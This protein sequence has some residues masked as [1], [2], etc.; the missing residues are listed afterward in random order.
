MKTLLLLAL[1]VSGN[2]FA[3]S[4]IEK[5]E[6]YPPMFEASC[7]NQ[8]YDRVGNMGL[9]LTSISAYVVDDRIAITSTNQ[10]WLCSDL[11]KDGT[12]TKMRWVNVDPFKGFEVPWYDGETN[13]N[14]TY[15][16]VIIN[17]DSSNKF[18]VRYLSEGSYKIIVSAPM[19]SSAKG[20][21][22]GTLTIT[23]ADLLDQNDLDLLAQGKEVSKRV[24]MDH[25]SA[26]TRIFKNPRLNDVSTIT[27]SSR[28][29]KFTFKQVGGKVKMNSISIE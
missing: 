2:S 23:Q 13:Q 20:T 11:A 8:D 7:G 15:H 22:K 14:D 16:Q 24:E 3:K 27:W 1:L 29:L 19:V 17:A 9:Q 26:M 10:L 18:E 28:Y 4:N 12:K 21:L 25:A 6:I 5:I